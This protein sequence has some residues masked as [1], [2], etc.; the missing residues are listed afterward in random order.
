MNRRN[1]DL[2]KFSECQVH[3]EALSEQYVDRQPSHFEE[4][5]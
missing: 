3:F 5:N 4:I 1:R 2:N